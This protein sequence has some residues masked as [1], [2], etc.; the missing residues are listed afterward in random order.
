MFEAFDDR[1]LDSEVDSEGIDLLLGLRA[2]DLLKKIDRPEGLAAGE[3]FS[4]IL[5]IE[6]MLSVQKGIEARRWTLRQLL[7]EKDSPLQET[8]SLPRLDEMVMDLSGNV[9]RNILKASRDEIIAITAGPSFDQFRAEIMKIEGARF[10][11]ER[12]AESSLMLYIVN[13][14]FKGRFGLRD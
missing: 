6:G 3:K 10:T 1:I 12:F 13:K 7:N 4:G 5:D 2:R 14:F 11:L 9:A 8:V